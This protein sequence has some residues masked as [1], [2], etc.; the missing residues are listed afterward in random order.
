MPERFLL[1][2]PRARRAARCVAWAL[3][4][5]GVLY[6]LTLTL[7]IRDIRREHEIAVKLKA[8]DLYKAQLNWYYTQTQGDLARA[9]FSRDVEEI[10]RLTNRKPPSL[11]DLLTPARERPRGFPPS[12]A[13]RAVAP[14]LVWCRRTD[15]DRGIVEE[16]YI[17]YGTG[18]RLLS[19]RV[20]DEPPVLY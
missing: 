13:Y 3:A 8:L 5:A 16:W 1:A 11:A 20:L 19:P 2:R 18:Y 6:L 12:P 17:W 7:G 14:G 9:F 15:L 10:R 4:V